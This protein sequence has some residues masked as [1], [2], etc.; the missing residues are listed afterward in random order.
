[1]FHKS[2]QSTKK[3]AKKHSNR[4]SITRGRYKRPGTQPTPIKEKKILQTTA[5]GMKPTM[6]DQTATMIWEMNSQQPNPPYPRQLVQP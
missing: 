2:N 6:I 4:Q 3:I 5:L 1:M